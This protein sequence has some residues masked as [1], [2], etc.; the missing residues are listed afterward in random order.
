LPAVQDLFLAA[1]ALG[2]GAVLTTPHLFVPG[3]FEKIFDIPSAFAL[4][5]VVPVR[6]PMGSFGPA[7]CPGSAL[8]VPR[9]R[10]AS[11]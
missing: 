7:T 4:C 2:S 10:F 3:R 1:R 6:D 9:D 8:V 11:R 5:A